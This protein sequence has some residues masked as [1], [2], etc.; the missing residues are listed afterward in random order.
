MYIKKLTLKNFLN[1]EEETFEFTNGINLL[2]GAN[3]QG[4]TNCGE[5]IF[6]LCTGYSPRVSKDSQVINYQKEVAEIEGVALSNYGDVKVSI[7]FNKLEK[8]IVKINEVQVNK[9]GE[10]MGNMHSVFFNPG[11][12]KIIQESPEDRRRFLN[13][14]LSQMSRPYF[15]A[16]NRYN[17]ILYQRNNLLKD[18]DVFM[19]KETLPVWDEQLSKESAKI[20][21]QRN[22]FLLKLAPIAKKIHFDLSDGR[23]ELEISK[24]NDYAG[25][26]EEIAK[27]FYKDLKKYYERDIRLG[28]TTIGPHRDDIKIHVNGENVKVYGSQGQQRT[29]ALS[30]KLAEVEMFREHFN[31]YPILI[32]DDVLSE[33]DKKRQKLLMKR[34]VGLQTILTATHVDRTVLKDLE[35]NKIQIEKGKVKRKKV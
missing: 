14:S 35:I 15:Y 16:L 3:A 18:K 26:E 22:E 9:I 4:K 17:K 29:A 25:S 21:R 10:L 24:E 6:Y 20:I 23:E 27:D 33:L 28:F 31:E 2:T 19:I 7:S 30:I 13:I 32:L 8:K 5:A 34:L 1:Y 11:E 12:L